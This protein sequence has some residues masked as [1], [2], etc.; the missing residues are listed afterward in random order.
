MLQFP[1]FL[2]KNMEHRT[3]DH[4]ENSTGYMSA[5]HL[6]RTSITGTFNYTLEERSKILSQHHRHIENF[7]HKFGRIIE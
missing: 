5:M 7:G 6:T 4:I 2:I 3:R 1:L